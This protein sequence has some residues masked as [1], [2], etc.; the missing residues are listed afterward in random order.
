MAPWQAYAGPGWFDSG[1][2][3]YYLAA[4]DGQGLIGQVHADVVKELS[5]VYFGCHPLLGDAAKPQKGG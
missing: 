3:H 4:C 2:G 1:G 5:Q